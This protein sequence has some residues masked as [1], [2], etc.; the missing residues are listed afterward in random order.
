MLNCGGGIGLSALLH[1]IL[2]QICT[3]SLYHCKLMCKNHTSGGRGHG[4]GQQRFRDY[5]TPS[6]DGV[7]VEVVLQYM[8]QFMLGF[9]VSVSNLDCASP[10][11]IHTALAAAFV[12]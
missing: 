11:H 12:V 1:S 9:F 5:V 7:D 3:L 4:V 8:H 6:N 2:D 10:L